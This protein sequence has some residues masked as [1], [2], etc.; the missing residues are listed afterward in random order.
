MADK[1][2]FKSM[3]SKVTSSSLTKNSKLDIFP[4]VHW[5]VASGHST[6]V[7]PYSWVTQ[8][9]VFCDAQKVQQ[10]KV[11]CDTFWG[12]LWS[13]KREPAGCLW[14]D[15]E[16]LGCRCCCTDGKVN[17][18][19]HNFPLETARGK[20]WRLLFSTRL[21]V[22][23][24]GGF[25]LIQEVRKATPVTWPVTCPLGNTLLGFNILM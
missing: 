25:S 13:M 21:T 8:V 12:V 20:C 14:W 6:P 2:Y 17:N 4:T 11:A 22:N 3:L 15:T 18:V 10:S 16:I 1:H 24:D 5:S 19:H 23:S 7:R 9:G